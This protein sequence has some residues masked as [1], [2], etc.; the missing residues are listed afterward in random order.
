MHFHKGKIVTASKEDILVSFCGVNEGKVLKVNP[1]NLAIL[2]LEKTVSPMYSVNSNLNIANTID[3][4][5]LALNIV[6]LRIKK[7]L[8]HRLSLY[9]SN[10]GVFGLSNQADIEFLVKCVKIIDKHLKNVLL[11]LRLRFEKD[12]GEINRY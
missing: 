5:A 9:K 3:L 12:F 1:S 2:G 10:S 6:L 4:K 11:K 7:S 8:V